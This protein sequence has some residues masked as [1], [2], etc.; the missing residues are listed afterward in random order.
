MRS[1]IR[2]FMAAILF[3]ALAGV[4]SA[5]DPAPPP[6]APDV[7][8]PVV[9]LPLPIAEPNP[10]AVEPAI[11]ADPNAPPVEP[12]LTLGQTTLTVEPVSPATA[13]APAVEV[14]KP[15][16]TTTTKRVTKKTATK[17]A[18]V[19]EVQMNESLKESAPSAST[20]PADTTANPPAPP[21]ASI[22]PLKSIAPVPPSVALNSTS[23]ETKSVNRMGIG[24]WLMAGVVI[25]GL[26]AGITLFRRRR[27]L[28]RKS[29]VDFTTEGKDL[30]PFLGNATL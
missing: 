30:K 18:A 21:A 28:K 25:A 7:A 23:E 22:E 17:P 3:T 14:E 4:V 26:F 19:P 9:L 16:V 20:A 6:P 5:Q 29:I 1:T 10:T 27:T 13:E 8:E 2:L 11:T 24:G 12:A 15:V